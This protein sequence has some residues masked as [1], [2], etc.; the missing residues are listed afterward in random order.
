MKK[1]LP[2]PEDIG[3]YISYDPETGELTWKRDHGKKVKQGQA[4][5]LT[6][7]LKTGHLRGFFKGGI[8]LAHRVAWF[9]H[10]GEQ[11]PPVLDH[12]NNTSTDN[13]IVNL[14]AAC[15]ATNKRNERIRKDNT[16]GVKGVSQTPY[17]TWQARISANKKAYHLG[18]FGSLEEAATVLHAARTELHGDFHNHG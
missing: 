18:S 12:I 11:P 2:I 13:R 7:N 3:D 14:R 17:G 1:A 6:S 5:F 15:K 8:Y 9:L 16:S 10:Y 4:A